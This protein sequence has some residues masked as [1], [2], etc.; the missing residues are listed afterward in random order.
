MSLRKQN[1]PPPSEMAHERPFDERKLN[2]NNV[3]DNHL[4]N[5]NN[6]TNEM[7]FGSG[8]NSSKAID[9]DNEDDASFQPTE[10]SGEFPSGP[11]VAHLRRTS[12]RQD[13]L[14]ELYIP[15]SIM[16][17]IAMFHIAS[18]QYSF[19][20]E[21]ST[22]VALDDFDEDT[23][24][25]Q[26]NF[27][28]RKA[29]YVDWASLSDGVKWAVVYDL[30][31]D[32]G[33]TAATR[34][35]CLST[36]EIISFRKLYRDEKAK[37]YAFH[38]R[39]VGEIQD[40]LEREPN[41]SARPFPRAGF[42]ATLAPALHLVTDSL[43]KAEVEQGRR[44]LKFLALNKYANVFN[45]WYGSG[46][47]FHAMPEVLDLN[48]DFL[49]QT[50]YRH[51]GFDINFQPE[52]K[53]EA[54]DQENDQ[55]LPMTYALSPGM[56][57]S[58]DGVHWP[59]VAD[60]NYNPHAM[61]S[62][63]QAFKPAIKDQGLHYT[64]SVRPPPAGYTPLPDWNGPGLGLNLI[65]FDPAERARAEANEAFR[66][67]MNPN[68]VIINGNE[69]GPIGTGIEN[70]GYRWATRADLNQGPE[71]NLQ[72]TFA[73]DPDDPDD[74]LPYDVPE[75]LYNAEDFPQELSE[76]VT[77]D[78]FLLY[79]YVSDPPVGYNGHRGNADDQDVNGAW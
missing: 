50:H 51:P 8:H 42:N 69:G 37:W 4:D 72:F 39:M 23:N 18:D 63:R 52:V 20:D 21:Y 45:K 53:L 77:D 49:E 48:L 15:N 60:E 57:N 35:L 24:D 58:M 71:G 14:Q 67:S 6:L 13:P 10:Q 55:H 27:E 5:D 76:E 36:D 30:T 78:D 46:S 22:E 25:E 65:V 2:K 74:F 33:F 54:Q 62:A 11:T 40:A 75:E 44:F 56:P 79:E 66:R 34:A 31:Q 47:R 29:A 12:P 28:R 64:Q 7:D 68:G 43:G 73:A 70:A 1:G 59:P 19:D 38:A 26:H 41:E 9:S 3:A 16:F 61:D 17:D 32:M